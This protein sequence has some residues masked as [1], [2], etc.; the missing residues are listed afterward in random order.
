MNSRGES[1][2]R[3]PGGALGT[4]RAPPRLVPFGDPQADDGR[5]PCTS[6]E[7]QT[8][9]AERRPPGSLALRAIGVQQEH[10]ARGVAAPHVH[11]PRRAG[12][13][14]DRSLSRPHHFFME[15]G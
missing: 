11:H 5:R 12:R 1:L 8:E 15:V 3:N 10:V 4:P 14:T 2:A 7:S 13:A 9:P 6:D